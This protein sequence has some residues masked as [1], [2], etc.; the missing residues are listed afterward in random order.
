MAT[1]T[2]TGSKTMTR[3]TLTEIVYN[4][5]RDEM[6]S[7]NSNIINAADRICKA[8]GCKIEDARELTRLALTC[9]AGS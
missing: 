9:L 5:V 3:K 2:Q 4:A 7:D 8:T 6:A 1:Q